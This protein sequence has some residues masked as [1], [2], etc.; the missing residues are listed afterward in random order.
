MAK[1]ELSM[2]Q[3]WAGCK[4]TVKH[5]E[6]YITQTDIQKLAQNLKL[7]KLELEGYIWKSFLSSFVHVKFWFFAIYRQFILESI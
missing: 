4:S 5:E 7:H 1:I 6:V 3:V 2:K